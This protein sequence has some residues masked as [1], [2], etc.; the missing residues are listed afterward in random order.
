MESVMNLVQQAI[1]ASM[2]YSKEDGNQIFIN[3]CPH[4]DLVDLYAYRGGYSKSKK[5]TFDVCI[6]TDGSLAPT[7]E[8][9]KEML[10]PIYDFINENP[11]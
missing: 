8:E 5:R 6:Y 10:K 1:I 3:V 2:N 9:A 11:Q 4:V 7:V